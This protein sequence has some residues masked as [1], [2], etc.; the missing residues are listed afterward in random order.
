MESET[1]PLRGHAEEGEDIDNQRPTT[2]SELLGWY[3]YAW[4]CEPFIVSAVG[5]YVPILLEQLAREN[6]FRLDDP[7]QPCIPVSSPNDPQNPLPPTPGPPT[8]PS[9]GPNKCVVPFFGKMIDTSS[10]ALY[11]FSLSVLVQTLVVI[12]MSGAADRGKF[13]KKLLVA[14]AVIG[15]TS[16]CLFLAVNRDRY[17]L[18]SFLA[19]MS[20]SAFGAV[21]VCGNAY[22]P[23]LV[24]NHPD[25]KQVSEQED[26]SRTR[27]LLTG[28]ISGTGVAI[29][30]FAAFLVQVATMVLVKLT[31]STTLS[32]EMAIFAVGLWWLVFQIPISLL[33]RSR[34][35][36][37]LPHKPQ[38]GV[39][40]ITWEYIKYGWHTLLMTLK[41][42]REMKDVAIFLVGWFIVSDGATT[43][44]SAAVLFARAEL[45]MS[46]PSLAIIG[47]LVVLSGMAGAMLVPRVVQ[48]WLDRK[49][50]R[51]SP[52]N[53]MLFVIVVAAVIPFYGILGFYLKS[54]G[55]RHEWEMFF[56]AAWYG[57]ALGG[58]NTT[59]RAV[60]SMLIPKGKESTFFSLFSVT[61]KGS[62]VIGPAITGLITDRTHN[63]RYTFYF[64]F[65]MLIIPLAV[66]SL[67]DMDRGQQ[68]AETLESID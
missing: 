45:Q 40:R 16:T 24:S 67:L 7:S 36:P 29:G 13:R 19:V 43:I 23:V 15:A 10:L 49:L 31:G 12:S 60:F 5:T 39:T 35:G 46:P 57:F 62:S 28:R 61:D 14:F 2:K 33:L 48:P 56:L 44:N 4:A 30:Y 47:V 11:T 25:V 41:E 68:E 9:R 32:L 3:C 21:S 65:A 6:G 17:Y 54:L 34:Q 55:L 64:L 66:F 8:D 53:G 50:A 22:L 27:S 42:A 18:A 26:I 38:G 58:L 59:A 1:S 51:P 20:N 37:P 52:V 63:I